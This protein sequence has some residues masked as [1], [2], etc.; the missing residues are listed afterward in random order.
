MAKRGDHVEA[1]KEVGAVFVIGTLVTL[2]TALAL[3]TIGKPK[4]AAAVILASPFPCPPGLP[5]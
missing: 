3:V 2:G 1:A 4:T 5:C